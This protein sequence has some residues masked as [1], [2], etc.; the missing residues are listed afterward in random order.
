MLTVGVFCKMLFLK[1]DKVSRAKF[2]SLTLAQLRPQAT[3]GSA[4]H[5]CSSHLFAATALGRAGIF[6]TLTDTV[7]PRT[8]DLPCHRYTLSDIRNECYHT[9]T[10]NIESPII[11]V[12][13]LTGVHAIQSSNK[14][15]SSHKFPFTQLLIDFDFV[16]AAILF[17]FPQ[18]SP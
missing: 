12:R 9:D 6:T 14:I 8:V 4:Q 2:Q 13:F 18:S 16:E 17:S 15:Q 1:G 5:A 7:A 3:T 11:I 10:V